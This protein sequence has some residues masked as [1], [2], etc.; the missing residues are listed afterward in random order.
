MSSGPSLDP[1]AY[2][3]ESCTSS[4]R[5]STRDRVPLSSPP[6]SDEERLAR[7]MTPIL[8]DGSRQYPDPM[9]PLGNGEL[10]MM[11]ISG[12]AAL[13]LLSAAIY[14]IISRLQL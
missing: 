5:S 12:A 8:D 10:L 4:T 7:P 13:V 14:A 3:G 11:G 2:D 9:D 1:E 6:Y